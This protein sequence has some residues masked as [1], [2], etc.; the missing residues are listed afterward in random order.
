MA[1]TAGCFV[2]TIVAGCLVATIVAAFAFAA[3]AVL[4]A[5]TMAVL[6]AGDF[7]FMTRPACVAYIVTHA[8]HD[9]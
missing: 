7:C 8:Q 9:V 1:D 5:F 4:A 3:L 6:A 2:A